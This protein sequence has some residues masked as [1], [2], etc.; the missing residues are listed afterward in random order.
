MGVTVRVES[1]RDGPAFSHCSSRRRRRTRSFGRKRALAIHDIQGQGSRSPVEGS[2]VTTS[3]VVTGR[4]SNGFFIQTPEGAADADAATSEGLFVFTGT[5]PAAAVTAGTLVSVSGR[6]IEFVPAPPLE[7]SADRDRRDAGRLRSR[8][9][10]VASRRGGD[11]IR[12]PRALRW[13]RAT[14]TARRDAW[15]A[16]H[17]DDDRG[18]VGSVVEA[19]ATGSSN[20]VFHGVATGIP[21]PFREPGIDVRLPLP[22]G[23]PVLRPALRREPRAAARGQRRAA[24]RPV[25]DVPA[26][27]LVEDLVGLLD[28][29]GASARPAPTRQPRRA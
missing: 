29:G 20:G 21:R 18:H 25:I 27:S 5:T 7:P 3:G 2:L 12:R 10:H 19:S 17:R 22:A 11:P 16:W 23:A 4:K 26:G 9:G 14:G 24:G 6:V 13:A 1:H 8:C 15:Y 28:V